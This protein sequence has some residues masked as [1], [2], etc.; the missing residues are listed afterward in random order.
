MT[1]ANDVLRKNGADT[2]RA[3]IDAAAQHQPGDSPSGQTEPPRK[4]TLLSKTKFI[5]G[6]VPPDYLV[7]GILQRGFL[8][9][10]TAKTGDGKTAVALEIAL[11]VSRHDAAERFFGSHTVDSGAVIYFAGENPD[12]LRMRVIAIDRALNRDGK[13]DR[14]AFI[15]G[16]FSILEMLAECKAKAKKV[17]LVIVDTSAAYFPG[18]SEN[19]NTQMGKHARTLRTL[20]ELPGKPCVLVLCHPAKSVEEASKLQPRG[21]GAFIAE[22][23]GNLTLWKKDELAE[24]FHNKMRGPG[25]EPITFRFE[26]I[27]CDALLDSKGPAHP[28]GA[29]R[30]RDRRRSGANE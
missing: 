15:P 12:D 4:P 8:Y 16:T 11:Q 30:C 18:D 1:D 5:G 24:L 6:F 28:V 19:E 17:D 25:F 2:L 22:L 20:A 9:G 23:D 26:K 3:G 27:I 10:L 14:I 21:G 7:D 29:R 13:K